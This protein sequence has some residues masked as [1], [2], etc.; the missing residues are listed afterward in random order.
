VAQPF[1]D[2]DRQVTNRDAHKGL[3]AVQKEMFCR[4]W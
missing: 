1:D 3:L 4:F 2:E